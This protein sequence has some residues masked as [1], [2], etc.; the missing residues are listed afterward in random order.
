MIPPSAR[1]SVAA[2]A[3]ILCVFLGTPTGKIADFHLSLTICH[4]SAAF[5]QNGRPSLDEP[6]PASAAI[7]LNGSD[8]RDWDR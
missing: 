1:L 5:R 7:F 3:A 6:A 8:S 2:C 4:T